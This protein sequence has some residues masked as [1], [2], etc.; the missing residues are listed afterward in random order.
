MSLV[1]LLRK[2]S[3][4]RSLQFFPN[5]CLGTVTIRGSHRH[6]A[7]VTPYGQVEVSFWQ[8]V[9]G[10]LPIITNEPTTK[11]LDK[12]WAAKVVLVPRRKRASAF[13]VVFDF[14]PRLDPLAKV[15]YQAIVPNDSEVFRLV[16][17]N[18]VKELIEALKKGTAHLT[19]R[20]EKGRS[21]L[22]VS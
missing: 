13:R 10:S 14:T 20:N 2:I 21:L 17:E 11:S 19:D 1:F 6:A 7:W 18:R 15:T 8:T 12:A 5:Q 4:P 16:R 22:S 9:N 3:D